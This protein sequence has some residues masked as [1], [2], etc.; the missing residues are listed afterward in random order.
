MLVDPVRLLTEIHGNAGF[1]VGAALLHPVVLLRRPTR[2]A[3]LATWLATAGATLVFGLGL[4]LYGPYRESVKHDLFVTTPAIGWLFE[5]KEHLAFG[6]VA[7]AWIGAVAHALEGRVPEARRPLARR[8]A[9]IGY[10]A[11]AA[12]AAFAAIAGTVV[13]SVHHL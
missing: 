4:A 11:A 6:A 7:F 10:V 5:R 8:L 3:P 9:R 1:M 13:A 2:R 12:M